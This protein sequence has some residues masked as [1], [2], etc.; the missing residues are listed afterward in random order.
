MRI[1]IN[2]CSHS[3]LQYG[4]WVDKKNKKFHQ[5]NSEYGRSWIISLCENLGIN[6]ADSSNNIF[7]IQ[8][9]PIADIDKK[10]NLPFSTIHEVLKSFKKKEMV[11]SIAT[12][13]K[14]NDSILMDTLSTLRYCKNNNIKIDY[15]L[16]QW[17]GPSR[18]LVSTD[19]EDL[20]YANP[21]ENF[22]YGVNF[23]PSASVITLNYMIILQG[24]LKENNI[25]Y[26]F[27]NY[28]PLDK[29]IIKLVPKI[30]R[31]LDLTK[32]LKYKNHHPII[33]G[34]IDHIKNDKLAIDNDGHPGLKLQ[35]I[36]GDMVHKKILEYNSKLL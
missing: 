17:S 10:T 6:T 19:K 13:G 3:R 24:Y 29:K 23:E 21:S 36:I 27:L 25:N 12:D 2:G 22:E 20:I 35:K 18:R 9:N 26:N 15:V 7:S 31:E 34:W 14:G 16:V 33:G 4:V 11:L 32:F 30:Y 1:L 8:T 28:F 5:P